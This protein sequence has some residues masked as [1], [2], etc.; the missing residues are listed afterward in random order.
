MVLTVISKR[1]ECES[2]FANEHEVDLLLFNGRAL[3]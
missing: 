1:K 2:H 3:D